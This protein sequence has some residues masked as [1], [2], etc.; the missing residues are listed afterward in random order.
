MSDHTE[1]IPFD[2]PFAGLE[3][4]AKFRTSLI[5]NKKQVI[6]FDHLLQKD[7]G[8]VSLSVPFS[9]GFKVYLLS[10][11]KCYSLFDLS[12]NSQILNSIFFSE[13]ESS[14]CQGSK[15]QQSLIL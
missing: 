5:I 9:V 8:A 14:D 2:A 4:S 3:S 1:Q 6:I 12:S 13:S 15:W 11:K 10:S 7:W